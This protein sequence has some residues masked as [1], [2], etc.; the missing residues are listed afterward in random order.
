MTAYP[1]FE[2]VLRVF[3]ACFARHAT[4][5]LGVLRVFRV[6]RGRTAGRS[7]ASTARQTAK[8]ART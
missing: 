1:S 8:A 4:P 7:Y 3:R 2:G 6:L 5:W